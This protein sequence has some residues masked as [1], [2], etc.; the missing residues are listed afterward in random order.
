VKMKPGFQNNKNVSKLPMISKGDTLNLSY[1][2]QQCGGIKKAR[3]IRPRSCLTTW[4]G[5]FVFRSV[6][7][8]W[9]MSGDN[10]PML[11]RRV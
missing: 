11:E 3:M 4:E 9:F 8:Q 7:G 2:G 5:F 1:F 10:E 6:S